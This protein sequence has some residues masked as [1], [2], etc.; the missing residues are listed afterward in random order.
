MTTTN[1][2]PNGTLEHVDP[3]NLQIGENVRDAV[4]LGK[5]FLS[6][7]KE[8][9]VLIPITA[10]RGDDGTLI[11]R[12]GQRRTL[13]ARQVGLA[14]VPVYVMPPGATDADA[15][16]IERI[17]HQI[18]TN[19]QKA[20]LTDAQRARGI[21]QMLDAGLSATKVAKSLS[22]G[23]DTVKAAAAAAGSPTAMEALNSGQLS[24]VEAAAVT[25]FESDPDAVRR[26]LDA[27]GEPRF[28]HTLA[29]LREER[30]S[31]QAYE[32]AAASYT[33]R[34]FTVLD[35]DPGWGNPSCVST[36]YLRTADGGEVTEAA[37]GDPAHWAVL[38]YEDTGWADR[39]T[40]E[41]IDSALIDWNTEDD[42]DA[43][44]ADGLR[45]FNSVVETTTYDPEW[46]CLDYTAA[47]LTPTE[48]YQRSLDRATDRGDSVEDDAD[49]ET[50]RLRREAEQAEAAKRD[51]RK[52]LAL[53]KLGAAAM[54][55]R[56][57]FVRALVARKTAPKGAARFV[58]ECLTRDKRLLDEYH[59]D[60]IAAELLGV[61]DPDAVRK[62][63]A[64]LGSSGD[65]R[66][67]VITLAL[68]LGALEGR[69][70]KDAWRNPSGGWG[71]WVKPGDY[72]KFLADNGYTLSDIEQ[73]ITGEQ[74]AD[75]VFDALS[76]SGDEQ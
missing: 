31:A 69:T 71:S 67:Q 41:I 48:L 52:T 37:I 3:A 50:A 19:D 43:Q 28:D 25:E 74:T 59:A 60:D 14:S 36:R 72:L 40:G 57:E 42:P 62:A 54:S 63:V 75:Q 30:A 58:A 26:L 6:S 24:L 39:E 68:V 61:D 35:N 17:V 13:G 4:D 2:E 12:N 34:G 51:R 55:V 16:R 45:H 29:Q 66:A 22:I 46:F 11:V 70:L 23:R 33:A 15:E 65:G 47:G 56:R 7:L 21:Q 44:A 5:D 27:A 18:V 76:D 32:A 49:A 20:D 38:L 64:N 53:N 1:T 8:H 9:G 10:V 73:V